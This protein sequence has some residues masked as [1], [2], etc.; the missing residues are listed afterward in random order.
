MAVRRPCPGRSDPESCRPRRW[1]AAAHRS[2]AP[3]PAEPLPAALAAAP[4]L[5]RWRVFAS[6]VAKSNMLRSPS[7]LLR[8]LLSAALGG[9]RRGALHMS[10]RGNLRCLQLAVVGL[11]FRRRTDLHGKFEVAHM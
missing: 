6:C 8:S 9:G 3:I 7:S 2:V 11:L 1:C 5:L 10:R 4:A